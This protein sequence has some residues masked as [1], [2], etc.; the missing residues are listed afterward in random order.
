METVKFSKAVYSL[1]AIKK[2]AYRFID[3]FSVNIRD[4]DKNYLVDL[5]FSKDVSPEAINFL[6]SDFSKEILDQDLRE[7]IKLE[8]EAYRNLIL[9]HVFSK[10]PLVTDE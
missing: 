5:F 2:A 6:L 9:A 8:T 1:Q 7:S 10:T 4:E 3:K